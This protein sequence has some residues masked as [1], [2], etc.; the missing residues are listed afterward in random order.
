MVEMDRAADLLNLAVE[1]ARRTI[2]S[3]SAIVRDES[4]VG[5]LAAMNEYML[6]YLNSMSYLVSLEASAWHL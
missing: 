5:L 2:Q 1:Q 6:K 3:H 4:D